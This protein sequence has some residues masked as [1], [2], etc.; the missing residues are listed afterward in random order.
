MNLKESKNFNLEQ[1]PDEYLVEL[2][3]QQQNQAS[4]MV[5]VARYA[6]VIDYKLKE[7]PYLWEDM[8]DV[9]QEALIALLRAVKNYRENKGARFSTYA[10]RCLDNAIKNFIKKDSAKK[11]QLLRNSV[12][13]HDLNKQ[14]EI[15]T[16]ETSPEKI[17]L[18]KE[19]YLQLLDR[20]HINLSEFEKNVLF[21]YLD[22]KS[23]TQISTSLN[24]SQKAV[25][26]ALQR[27]RRKL[28]MV[29]IQ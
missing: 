3:Q 24:S 19:R 4:M 25:D 20:I 29:F 21:C 14:S 26:N 18:D 5:L 10:N 17:Y 16:L 1:Y 22:G 13:I 9:R 15:F 12:S 6:V 28:K 2:Y 11:L 23:Y 27:V 7:Y 8:D